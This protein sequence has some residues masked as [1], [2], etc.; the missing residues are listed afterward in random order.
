MSWINLTGP[1]GCKT[2]I[3]TQHILA[4]QGISESWEPP[5]GFETAKTFLMFTDD[6]NDD[7]LFRETPEEIDALIRNATAFPEGTQDN[8]HS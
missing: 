8:E 3:Q 4:Y 1:K 2:R 7:N 5:E 6:D